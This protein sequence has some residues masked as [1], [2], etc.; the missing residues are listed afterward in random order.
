M[1]RIEELRRN[2]HAHLCSDVIF[3]K[4]G[5]KPSMADVSNK[6]SVEISR[7]LIA[8][9]PY[10]ISGDSIKGQ[11]AGSRLEELTK[12]FLQSA[13]EYIQHIRPGNWLFSVHQSIAD[14]DQYKHI[15]DLD[16][17]LEANPQLKTILGDYVIAPDIIVARRPLSDDEINI[18]QI[19]VEGT[20]LS[21]YTPLR[22][23]NG[24]SL[25]LHASISCKWTL[26]SDRSQNT[27]TEGLNLMRNRKGHTPH[28]AVVT[29]EP[30]PSRI[31][32]IALGTGDIDCV[33]HFA[34][35]ELIQAVRET[36]QSDA[37]EMLDIMVNGR[38]LRDISDL[39]FDL[40][41]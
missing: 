14:F 12:D 10:P 34:L 24:L 25:I 3:T 37:I 40:A 8:L 32:S 2:Y 23:S 18:N 29:G 19:L 22:S 33:Y 30:T 20:D 16:L 36:N 1:G 35:P 7:N 31:A 17:I 21:R 28:I 41:I 11:T 27:R 13:F 39:P 15:N 26:R 5:D 6:M 9:L 4:D 38:R